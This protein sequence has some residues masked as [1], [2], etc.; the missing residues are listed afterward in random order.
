MKDERGDKIVAKFETTAPK[1]Y[2][3]GVQKND[4]GKEDF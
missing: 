4:H 2:G 1:T 3:Y